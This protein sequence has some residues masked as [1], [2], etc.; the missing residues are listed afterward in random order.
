M[1]IYL[2]V[3]HSCYVYVFYWCNM[4]MSCKIIK[5]RKKE[6]RK[7]QITVFFYFLMGFLVFIC[8]VFFFY[9]DLSC[10]LSHKVKKRE[11]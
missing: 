8:A 6:I 1:Y 9:I 4:F 2:S 10:T 5:V 7:A 11:Q 3:K